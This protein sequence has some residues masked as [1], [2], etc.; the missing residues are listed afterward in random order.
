MRRKRT[1]S[2]LEMNFDEARRF[3]LKSS[4]FFSVS[5]PQYFSF[6]KIINDVESTLGVNDSSL[7]YKPG[8]KPAESDSVNYDLYNNKDGK[9]SWR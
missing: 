2:L 9:Y 3:L 6:E 1:K 4:S 7:F 5:L 8:A